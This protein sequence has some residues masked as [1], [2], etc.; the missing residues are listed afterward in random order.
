[1]AAGLV[2]TEFTIAAA[3]RERFAAWHS[4][5]HAQERLDVPGV[6]AVERYVDVADP[7]HFC[8]CYRAT[9]MEIYGSPAY[10]A[11]PE[12][13]SA[14]TRAILAGLKGT[15][16]LGETFGVAGGGQGGLMMRLRRA[17]WTAAEAEACL[18]A[19]TA[20]LE[21]GTISRMEIGRPGPGGP[22][23]SDVDWIVLLEGAT[24]EALA[25][26]AGRLA[27]GATGPGLFRLEHALR[28]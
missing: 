22:N 8:C 14:M 25:D 21:R 10:A 4:R 13:A 3:D 12:R 24:A 18:A 16:F 9:G 5:E 28:A 20:E 15:R 7:L 23:V 27:A 17:E 2:F 11:L 19:A 6:T 1:M 26:A